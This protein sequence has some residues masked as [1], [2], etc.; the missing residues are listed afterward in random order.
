[1]L[2]GL[3]FPGLASS[4]YGYP[5]AMKGCFETVVHT[6]CPRSIACA[7]AAIFQAEN[8]YTSAVTI[9]KTILTAVI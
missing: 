7:K 5:V 2:S 1:M 3:L 4:S 9:R 6:S 8:G